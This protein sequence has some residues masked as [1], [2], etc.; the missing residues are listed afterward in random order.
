MRILF[1]S[2]S[3]PAPNEPMSNVGG[4]QRVA[5]ELYTALKGADGIDVDGQ[6]L[7]S[8]FFWSHVRVVPFMMSSMTRIRRMAE[9]REVDV[10]LF[11]S[12][13]TASMVVKLKDVLR[14]NGVLS[15]AIVHGLDVTASFAP[16]QRFVPRVF[17]ALDLVLPVSR[18]TADACVQRGLEP[19][20]CIVVPNGIDTSRFP[21]PPG[22][23][24]ARRDLLQHVIPHDVHLS[25]NDFVL[26]SVGRHVKRKGFAWF[27]ENVMPLLPENVHYWMAGDG[28]ER[29]EIAAAI[30]RRGLHHR[31]RML[32]RLSEVDLSRL[33]RGADLFVMPNIPV[34]GDME[35]FG[36]VML[37]AGLSGL[38]VIASSLEGI[39]DV[40]EEGHNGHLIESGNAWEFSEAIARYI[41]A[42]S[43]LDDAATDAYEFVRGRFGWPAVAGQYTDVLAER[44]VTADRREPVLVE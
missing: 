25:E 15:A 38:P 5:T 2:H 27:V 18:A 26:V 35:G 11:S 42:P 21:V 32:G 17:E 9:R 19:S 12:M 10:V 8:S 43:L 40:V 20:R 6:L 34:E 36:V 30:S 29:E 33:Y 3:L 28:P 16:Y 7:Q 23:R 41:Y 1:V 4:M 44:V 31:V 24:K 13:V 39:L 37:E 22:S 14:K